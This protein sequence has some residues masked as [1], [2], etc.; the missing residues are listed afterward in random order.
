MKC[1]ICGT[2]VTK[3]WYGTSPDRLCQLDYR[4]IQYQKNR[5]RI[6][7][8]TREKYHRDPKAKVAMNSRYLAKKKGKLTLGPTAESAGP[9]CHQRVIREKTLEADLARLGPE[10][11]NTDI[12]DY[13]FAH[14][15]MHSEHSKFIAIYEWLGSVGNTPKW[16]FTSRYRNV[17]A[18]VVMINEPNSYSNLLGPD[19]RKLEAL[20]QRGA[21][22]S[23]AHQHLGSKLIMFALKWMVRHTDKRAFVAYSD[24]AAGEIGTIYQACNFTY[25]GRQFGANHLYQHRVFKKG[26]P[27]SIQSLRRTS[28]LKSFLKAR[29]ITWDKSWEKANGF[30]DLSRLPAEY[31]EAWYAWG[32]Q[33]VAESAKVKLEK[34]GKY[35]K[36]IGRDKRETRRLLSV[37]NLKKVPYPKR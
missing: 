7:Q 2:T 1:K 27:F 35:C 18:G 34:K 10:F 5:D 25:L 15:Q 13:S 24:P 36:I 32:N 21:C 29:G 19:N 23:W 11:Q 9:K 37:A 3:K 20:I 28:V 31:K 12:K 16:V 26:K 33:I 6:L 22:A 17:L 14:E 30:K 8:Q 4:K